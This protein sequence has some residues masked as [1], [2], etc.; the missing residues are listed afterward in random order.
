L[1]SGVAIQTNLQ[2]SRCAGVDFDRS[3]E[4]VVLPVRKW[5]WWRAVRH[6]SLKKRPFGKGHPCGS[7]SLPFKSRETHGDHSITLAV[8][9]LPLTLANWL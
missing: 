8:Q 9:C 1:L 3:L 6:V 2:W 4:F 7:H 5:C